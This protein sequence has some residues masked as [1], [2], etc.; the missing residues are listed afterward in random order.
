MTRVEDGESPPTAAELVAESLRRRP[1]AGRGLFL[2]QL[3]AHALASLTLLEG[4]GAASEAA[5]RL[6][7]AAI[8]PRRNG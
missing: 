3:M 6:A 5:Y 4:P 7:D 8:S 1:P 2:R